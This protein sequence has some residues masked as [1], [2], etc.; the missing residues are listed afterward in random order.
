[1]R[2]KKIINYLC[3]CLCAY[4]LGGF[5]TVL[6][7]SYT[8]DLVPYNVTTA[9]SVT[10]SATART[11]ANKA[12]NG[13]LST[14]QTGNVSTGDTV[15]ILVNFTA[16][17]DGTVV[18]LNPQ[19]NYDPTKLTYVSYYFKNSATVDDSDNAVLPSID[20]GG[21][22][23]VGNP[24]HNLANKVISMIVKDSATENPIAGVSGTLYALFFT[25]GDIP[26]GG[27]TT[28]EFNKTKSSLSDVNSRQLRGLT[29][30]NSTTL[31]ALS[32]VSSD[33]TLKELVA[34]GN[35][36]KTYNFDFKA[37]DA[38]ALNYSFVVPNAVD[39]ITFTGSSTDSKAQDINGLDVAHNLDVG[40]NSITIS[41]TAETGDV[42]NYQIRVRRLSNDATLKDVT[43][44]NGISF[45]LPSNPTGTTV[46]VPSVTVPYKTTSTDV[47]A[48]VTY[49]ESVVGTGRSH[50]TIVSGLGTWEI[51]TD[52]ATDTSSTFPVVVNAEDCQYPSSDVPGNVCTSKTY[53]FTIIRTAPSTDLKLQDLTVDGVTV[54]GFSPTKYV[55]NLDPVINSK[56]SVVI[57][58]T[59]SDAKNSIASSSNIGTQVVNVGDN[60]YKIIVQG[61]D[62]LPKSTLAY[63]IKIHRLSNDTRLQNL[64]VDSNPKGTL[65]PAF[66][67]SL[68][69][70]YTYTYDPT[71]SSISV[72]ATVKDTGKASISI[73]DMSTSEEV[74]NSSKTLNS[75]TKT[76]GITTTK[77]GVVV[78]A[79]DGTVQVY[80][81]NLKRT[82]SLNNYLDGLTISPGS[83]NETFDSKLQNYTAEVQPDV[84]SVTVNPTLSDPVNAKILSITGNDNLNFGP[85][86]IHIVVKSEEGATRQ[87][88]IT[89]TRKKYDIDTLDNISYKFD[90][91]Q[92]ESVPHFNANTLKYNLSTQEDPI[93]FET[94]KINI[95]YELGEEHEIVSGNVGEINLNSFNDRVTVQTTVDGKVKN[96]LK[97]VF[98][99]NV[100]SHDEAH[101]KTYELT[102][103]QECNPDNATTGVSVHGVAAIVDNQD[104]HIYRVVLRNEYQEVAPSNVVIST[105]A[106]MVLK[107]TETLRLSTTEVNIFRYTITSESGEVASYEIHITREPSKDANIS[108]IDL[109]TDEGKT[110][111]CVMNPSE[112]SCTINVDTDTTG[113]RLNASIKDTSSVLPDN[114]THYDMPLD[115]ESTQIRTLTV[116]P[117]SGEE[118]KKEYTI[119]IKRSLSSDA[120]LKSISITDQSG[121]NYGI[122]EVEFDPNKTS[123]SVKIPNHVDVVYI[124]AELSDK[125]AEIS[126]DLP[127]EAVLVFD[128]VVTKTINITAEDNTATKTYYVNF[129]REKSNDATLKDL[130][131]DGKT[132]QGF[133]PDATS[134]SYP[135]VDYTKTTLDI[136]AITS[137][138]YAKV[139]SMKVRYENGTSK[140]YPFEALNDVTQTIDL[141][142]GVNTIE[143]MTIP[144][145]GGTGKTYTVAVTRQKNNNTDIDGITI[146]GVAAKVDS[147]NKYA[148]SATVS[149]DVNVANNLN[150]VVAVK[151][152]A[153]ENDP[154]ATYDV[155]ETN[156]RTIDSEGRVV[157]NQV[158]INVTSEEGNV[159]TYILN[160]IRLASNVAT[161]ERLNLYI[162]GK[163]AIYRYC[164]FGAEYSDNS[165]IL[166]VPSTVK[167]IRLEGITTDGTASVT[168]QDLSGNRGPDFA[169]DAGVQSK[170]IAVTVLAEDQNTTRPYRVTINR[171]A[172][173]DK[174]VEEVTA[175]GD[176][177]KNY[178]V[179]GFGPTTYQVTV[180]GDVNE[181]TLDVTPSDP[182]AQVNYKGGDNEDSDTYRIGNGKT[183]LYFYVQS[184]AGATQPY[185]VEVT[186]LAKT[187]NTLSYLNY[188]LSDGHA[189][190]IPLQEGKYDYEIDDVLYTVSSIEIGAIAHDSDASVSGDI[191]SQVIKTGSNTYVIT[192]T[193][194]NGDSQDYTITVVRAKNTDATLKI[195]ALNGYDL[196]PIATTSN[197]KKIFTYNVTV[198]EDVTKILAS[199]INAV[200]TD[201]A[202]A[203]VTKT[204]GDLDLPSSGEYRYTITVTPEDRDALSKEYV[205]VITKPASTDTK[206]SN[207][208]LKGASITP[209]FNKDKRDGYTITVPYD[210][211]TFTITGIPNVSS[212]Q[213]I[214]GDGTY[215]VSDTTEVILEV[216]SESGARGTYTFNVVRAASTDSSLA[217]LSVKGYP[218][219]ES[220][221][222][223]KL[224]YSIGDIVVTTDKVVVNASPTNA[225]ST[226]KYYYGT[227]NIS[228]CDNMNSCEIALDNVVG[229]KTISIAVQAADGVSDHSTTYTIK[230]KK[231]QSD[232]NYLASIDVVKSSDDSSLALDKTFNKLLTDYNVNVANDVR[233]V[234][235]NLVSED[236]N[237]SISVNGGTAKLNSLTYVFDNLV[238][239][240]NTARITVRAANGSENT[241]H[242]YIFRAL[243]V[244]SSD[245]TLSSLNIYNG[246]SNEEFNLSPTF[247][248]NTVDY[249]IGEIPYSLDTLKIDA[250]INMSGSV[251]TY[252]LDGVLV[253]ATNG[254]ISIPK[255]DG[256]KE[257]TVK[258]VAEDQIAVKEYK[259]TYSKKAEDDANLADLTVD[260]YDLYPEFSPDVPSYVINIPDDVDS[261]D[262]T[263]IASGDNATITIDGEEI[264]DGSTKTISDLPVGSKVVN[265]TVTAEDG[266]V[267]NYTIEIK[268]GSETLDVIT[269]VEYGHEI[270]EEFVMTVILDTTVDVFK[271][272]FD[273][274]VEELVLYAADGVTVVDSGKVGTG[275]ILR[276]V[277]DGEVL[278]SKIAVLKGDTSGDGVITMQDASK[279]MS[280]YLETESLDGAY[281]AAADTSG[282]NVVTM[283]DASKIMSH[284]LETELL[285]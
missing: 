264:T 225:N 173:D 108:R 274:P 141:A 121:T 159:Q 282:D 277:R 247:A 231:V 221:S 162:D 49:D 79:E 236:V 119:T 270:T 245:A 191:G 168:Y 154:K 192:V 177:G 35:N 255:V 87:Y 208:D 32:D 114:S 202:N 98:R 74:D 72:L 55:Y 155:T 92:V 25:V 198:N 81:V 27:S 125:K 2:I 146:A 118:N 170:I 93:P 169:W 11:C 47:V 61:E 266:T 200:A 64:E 7:E 3:V 30:F 128:S 18:S 37:S 113:Y 140:V 28:I 204:S 144:Q 120:K 66:G 249:S 187:D 76:F 186:R 58:A 246:V 51:A 261:I 39:A 132:I 83:L 94:E 137:D 256:E 240:S 233:S 145:A 201:E 176:N 17:S 189:G 254:V 111:Y 279:V 65:N 166:D 117:E 10:S 224:G 211:E 243:P 226:W 244:A 84:S 241:Y 44:T 251:V 263:A 265:I 239:G 136:E 180:D 138:Q 23:T 215:N 175:V 143:I 248:P 234:T 181:I 156:L 103:Y 262:I 237:A 130:K 276:L 197:L 161:L 178:L 212:S 126:E 193:A 75:D 105:N 179:N 112:N 88:N 62:G 190:I 139:S 104:L 229:E 73:I 184:E 232:N 4:L 42:T 48:S 90:D 220:F 69:G 253:T 68:S 213:V 96:V 142:T 129:T 160:V 182:N 122:S 194:Q 164:Q 54:P 16:S 188:T 283:Q 86:N 19:I 71:V 127:I 228:A 285:Y 33:G 109:T 269:S 150:V 268:K 6:A 131:I 273:N 124:N 216:E 53:N 185:T 31:N 205:I 275:M 57:G 259:I 99:I 59:L 165:C 258:V 227:N 67:D 171:G 97:Y 196:D 91:G 116:T 230:Y 252:Y 148:Y 106:P 20:N 284:Y 207:I 223:T 14:Y 40:D 153:T 133:N 110:A 210:N 43:A 278:D 250:R 199:S 95:S 267:E 26:A 63:T 147:V 41:V 235:L 100:K 52:N 242:V 29:T 281:L 206:L 85:N 70:E 157:T 203:I 152:G 271:T 89:V 8:F 34:T 209:E 151:T 174:G 135:I 36:N 60:E 257:I 45:N 13:Q 56:S 1:M 222:S 172:N 38:S 24:N 238:E 101:T 272:Q 82:K 163:A 78:T 115:G 218:F 107:Q 134:L 158:L 260:G 219:T 280:H 15:M 9:C 77:V 167:S 149:N 22:W 195:L 102:L 5:T 217:T 46:T 183:T 80:K 123:Y 12:L 21:D 214:S 50:A